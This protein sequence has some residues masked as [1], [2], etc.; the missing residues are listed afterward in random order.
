MRH[1]HLLGLI[2]FDVTQHQGLFHQDW[3]LDDHPAAVAAFRAGVKSSG[4][5]LGMK[6]RG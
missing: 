4:L 2:Y 1:D 3:R 5:T 6:R